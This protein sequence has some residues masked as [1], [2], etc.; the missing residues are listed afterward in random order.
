MRIEFEDD[1]YDYILSR[2]YDYYINSKVSEVKNNKNYVTAVVHGT[3]DYNVKIEMADNIFIDGE[4]DCPYN[5]DGVY[6]KH[7]A[8]VLYYLNDKKRFDSNDKY[9]LEDIINRIDDKKIKKTLYN[10]LINDE[11]LLNRFRVE[12]SEFFPK[13]SKKSYEKKIYNAIRSCGDR[14]YGFIDYE[15][16]SKYEHVMLEFIRETEKLVEDHDYNT[17]FT[18]VTILLDSIPETEIDD[19][20]GS[21]GMVAESCIEIIFSIL[22][23]VSIDDELLKDIFNYVINEI[24][25]LY[26]YNY[27]IDLKEI[28]EYFIN[29]QLYL[30]EIKTSLEIALDNSK[31]KEYFYCRQSYVEYLIKIYIFKDERENII[32]ILEEYSFDENICM[33]YVD[34]LIKENKSKDAI[35][36]L[37]DNLGENNYKNEKYA[38]K[39]AEIYSDNGM[40]EE[41]KNILYDIFYKYSSFDF[42]IYLKIKQLY[43]N[44]EWNKESAKVIENIKKYK[45]VN[46]ILNQVYIEEKMYDDL[47]LNICDYNMKYIKEYEKY[48]LPKYNSELLDIYK[49]SCLNLAASANN[50]KAY[51]D[52]AIQVKHIINMKNSGKIVKLIFSEINEKYFRNRP[53]MVDEFEKV[54][55]NLDHYVK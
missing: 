11:N 17:A 1:F 51:S 41:Y 40:N 46:R 43:S 3:N 38:L 6:C 13:L 9:N 42:D 35:K 47:F 37:N 19:S 7:M 5:K 54:I 2:G 28:L 24:K 52:V 27:G 33:M 29:K 10:I 49:E 12:F 34:E 32:K 18:I 23:M 39:L 4:C 31:S 14:K 22:N 44:K 48:L 30:N 20:N 21:T 16:S 50:R 15:N 36:I 53:A 45:N 55:N 25:S 8:A 26:L